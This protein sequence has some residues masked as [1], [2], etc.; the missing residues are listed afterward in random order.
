MVLMAVFL[1]SAAPHS[2]KHEYSDLHWTLEALLWM[3]YLMK[4]LQFKLSLAV[5]ILEEAC[6]MCIIQHDGRWHS[7]CCRS[8]HH[9]DADEIHSHDVANL[10]AH[11]GCR[12]DQIRL[13]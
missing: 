6:P 5:G 2:A 1:Q 9:L 12:I 3:L 4:R 11:G 8:T 10:P 7:S 13:P